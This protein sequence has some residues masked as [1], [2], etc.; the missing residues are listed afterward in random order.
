M[1]TIDGNPIEPAGYYPSIVSIVRHLQEDCHNSIIITCCWPFS[2]IFLSKF[3]FHLPILYSGN[4]F[5]LCALRHSAIIYLQTFSSHIR[6]VICV[7]L[8]NPV[9]VFIFQSGCFHRGSV[10]LND[11][12]EGASRH[13]HENLNHFSNNPR[14]LLP[15]PG[16]I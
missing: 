3:L 10:D 2:F 11:V 13:F 7:W 8:Y 12:D 6:S 5:V 4:I 9:I 15:N 16:R 1:W 14:R